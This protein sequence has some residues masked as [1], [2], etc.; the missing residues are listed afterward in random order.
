[1]NVNRCAGEKVKKLGRAILVLALMVT[2]AFAQTKSD[3]ELL[4]ETVELAKQVKEFGKTLGIEPSAHLSESTMNQKPFSL[5]VIHIQKRGSVDFESLDRSMLGFE[6]DK[7]QMPIHSYCV[8][9]RL[10]S[11]FLRQ[12]NEF[13]GD[14]KSLITLGF[15]K[16][17]LARKVMVIFHKDLHE[18]THLNSRTSDYNTAETLV[19]PLG[20]VAALKYFEHKNDADNVKEISRLIAY[21]RGLSRELNALESDIKE[22]SKNAA[23]PA[24]VCIELYEKEILNKYPAYR[25]YLKN[26]LKPYGQCEAEEAAITNDLMYWKYFDQVVSLY[27]KTGNVKTLIEDFENAPGDK[28]DL[29]KYLDNLNKKYSAAAAK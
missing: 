18:N 26:T 20:F 27:D 23:F 12:A 9:S 10:Y 24:L 21:Y 6:L 5:L 17:N 22:L 2:T 14:S 15:A 29:E 16:E 25:Q 1:M 8:W 19:T 11:I 3:E 7:D 4:K 13:A 28:S